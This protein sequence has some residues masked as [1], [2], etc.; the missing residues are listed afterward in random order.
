MPG[1]GRPA[2]AGPDIY[3]VLFGVS[4]LLLAGAAALLWIN[5]SKIAPE[6]M[7]INVQGDRIQLQ[8]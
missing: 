5:G 1:G 3:T 7:P 8:R 2:T 6:G 4:C